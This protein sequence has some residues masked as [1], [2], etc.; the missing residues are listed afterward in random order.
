MLF[1]LCIKYK[2]AFLIFFILIIP[3]IFTLYL[4]ET[5]QI[6]KAKICITVGLAISISL[7]IP[8]SKLFAYFLVIKEI[9]EINRFCLKIREGKYDLFFELPNEDEEESEI[10]KLKRNMNWMLRVISNRSDFLHSR[11]LESEEMKKEF[12][13]L[14]LK[15]PLTSLYNRRYFDC[16]IRELAEK[17]KESHSCFFL[18]LID[19][20]WF[21]HINDKLGHQAGDSLLIR[22]A[23]IL[24]DS[25]RK[26]TDFPFRYGGDEFGVIISENELKKAVDV[27]ERLRSRYEQQVE[28]S[29]LSIGI[30]EFVR[31]NGD[32][33]KDIQNLIKTADSALYQSKN[34]GRNKITVIA[35]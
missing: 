17:I 31:S 7:L 11:I 2:I 35:N 23:Q 19:I 9:R 20:D 24:T 33:Q 1:R 30:A 14:S 22:L 6:E 15:D 8:L 26:G 12:K 27:A 4:I 16:K 34:N 10:I 18:M 3:E 29:T 32:I 5:E 25:T 21:K 13:D 28:T